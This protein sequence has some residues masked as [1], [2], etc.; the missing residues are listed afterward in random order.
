MHEDL[1]LEI[2]YSINYAI[3]FFFNLAKFWLEMVL[4][5]A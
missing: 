4:N 3:I 1:K 2:H 5:P